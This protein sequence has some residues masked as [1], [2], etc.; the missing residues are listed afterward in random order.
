MTKSQIKY[1][2]GGPVVGTP[3]EENRWDYIYLYQPRMDIGSNENSQRYWLI[4]YFQNEKV[5]GIEK[6]VE[7]NPN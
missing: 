3:Y 5:T 4:V 6:D 2:L 7:T 1:L